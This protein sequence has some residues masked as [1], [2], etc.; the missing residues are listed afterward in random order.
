MNLIE[1][2]DRIIKHKVVIFKERS[3]TYAQTS[4]KYIP[5]SPRRLQPWTSYENKDS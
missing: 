1:G 5:W 2:I 4:T 3:I